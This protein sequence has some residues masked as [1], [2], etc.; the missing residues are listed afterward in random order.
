MQQ[1]YAILSVRKNRGTERQW[2]GRLYLKHQEQCLDTGEYLPPMLSKTII[3]IIRAQMERHNF[4]T[5]VDD[6]P[7]IAAFC[8]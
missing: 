3:A 4:D 8:F 6:P 2:Q 7:S 1:S 5:Y